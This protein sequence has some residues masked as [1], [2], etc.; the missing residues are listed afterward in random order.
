M[1]G[2]QG[3]ECQTVK[4]VVKNVTESQSIRR[5]AA[6]LVWQYYVVPGSQGV[7]NICGQKKLVSI[8]F[9]VTMCVYIC[10]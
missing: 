7:N 10:S 2:P 6:A 3:S 8:Y 4:V 1:P 5:I 9:D